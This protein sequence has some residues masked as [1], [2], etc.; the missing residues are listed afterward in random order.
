MMYK[1][2]FNHSL[3]DVYNKLRGQRTK[4]N[5]RDSTIGTVKHADTSL[6]KSFIKL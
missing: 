6:D 1:G 5:R 3:Y 2:M 4:G